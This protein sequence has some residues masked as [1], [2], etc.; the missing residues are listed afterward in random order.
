MKTTI[1]ALAAVSAGTFAT[2][3]AMSSGS[4]AGGEVTR[5]RHHGA[6]A[7]SLSA[8]HSSEKTQTR[9]LQAAFSNCHV[10]DG[11]TG[12]GPDIF[13]GQTC[14]F[15]KPAAT[16]DSSFAYSDALKDSGIT[17]NETTLNQWLGNLCE[18]NT[19]DVSG[20]FG[21]YGATHDH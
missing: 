18:W 10:L 13:N 15:D 12:A 6:A 17:W 14:I 4:G 20:G 21:S 19:N 1:Q 8:P 11:A 16:S 5:I 2:A 9:K 7:A 3:K